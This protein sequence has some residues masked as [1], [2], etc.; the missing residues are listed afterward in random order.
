MSLDFRIDPGCHERH[1]RRR[2]DNPLFPTETRTVTAA[3]LTD[4]QARDDRQLAAF[5][6]DFVA[7]LKQAA[8]LAA[9]VESD[10]VLKLKERADELYERCAGLAG[11]RSS[12]K[13]ALTRLIESIMHA[14]RAGATGDAQALAELEQETEARRL[15]QQ[16]LSHPLVADLLNPESPIGAQE[17]VPSLLNETETTLRTV[18]GLFDAEQRAVLCQQA[19]QLLGKLGRDGID[20]AQYAARL[21]AME[22]QTVTHH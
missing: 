5:Q 14:V 15:H 13:Q 17:L 20:T 10:V 11:D 2:A 18:M 22:Q 7:L 21:Q 6:N 16:L 1:L 9:N 4:A 12:E 3:Q 19:Q 8:E